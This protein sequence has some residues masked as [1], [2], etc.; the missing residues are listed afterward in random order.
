MKAP[1]EIWLWLANQCLRRRC[2][3][4]VE[5]GQRCTSEAY[6]SVSLQLRWANTSIVICQKT[7][8]ARAW[9][10][11]NHSIRFHKNFMP[12]LKFFNYKMYL[13]F[14]GQVNFDICLTCY[15]LTYR[16][17]HWCKYRRHVR[18][19][20]YMAFSRWRHKK[21]W[22]KIL[23]STQKESSLSHCHMSHIMRKPVYAI[24]E[25]HR[26]S[27]I[28]TFLIHCLNSIL[29]LVSISEISSL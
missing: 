19:Q 26:C 13:G 10:W 9:P 3:N 7:I 29:S 17:R 1:Y 24:C 23:K 8:Y 6:L 27:L 12:N 21:Q 18:A 4:S 2:L 28:N 16:Q 15:E 5:D 20:P 11:G 22:L 14:S 25:Q